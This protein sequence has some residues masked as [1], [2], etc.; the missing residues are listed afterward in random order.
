MPETLF[1]V[2]W[3]DGATGWLSVL[4]LGL[5]PVGVAFFCWDY[6]VKHGN[7]KALGGMSY[8]A[9]LLSTLLLIGAGMAEASA[10]IG[11]ACLA[12]IGGAL[13]A[14]RDLWAPA[15]AQA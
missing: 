13:L 10:S 8:A 2:R 7:I 15:A 12:I 9:P 3:P 11:L 4:A 14:A 6:G 1:H 5:G